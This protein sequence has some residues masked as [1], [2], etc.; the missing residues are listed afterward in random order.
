MVRMGPR[1]GPTMGPQLGPGG[2][3]AVSPPSG[4]GWTPSWQVLQL[5]AT[6]FTTNLVVSS[7]KVSTSATRYV[8]PSGNNAN[9]GTSWGAAHRSLWDALN[10][11]FTAGVAVTI[12]V[13]GSPDPLNPMM[14]EYDHAWRSALAV[15]AN[16]I[17]VSDEATLAPG[18]AISSTYMKPGGADLGTWALV[19]GGTPNVYSATLAAAPN[20]V[21]D[22][23]ILSSFGAGTRLTL[24]TSAADVEA[25]PGSYYFA[26][27][28][29][30]V[31]TADSRAPDANLRT[32]KAGVINGHINTA[33]VDCYIQGLTFE[34]GNARCLFIQAATTVTLVDCK[35]THGQAEGLSLTSTTAAGD[36]TLHL[37]R[38]K[39]LDC[40][41]DGLQY[42][43]SGAGAV[44][45]VLEWDCE[46][47]GNS[48]AGADQGSTAHFTAG[49]TSV[50][51][52][53]VNG[54]Y[55]HNKTQG[56]ADV[57]G[58][59]T[60]MLGCRF[61]GESTGAY[62][63]DAGT[64]WLHGCLMSGNTTDL[65]TDNASG[66]I[67]VAGTTYAT[68]SGPGTIATYTP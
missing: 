26:A 54:R 53:R 49:N 68:S 57:G 35:A 7:L 58:C 10:D 8:S 2:G 5:S 44:C 28:T 55:H 46:S 66:N 9:A 45:R 12:Y 1:M 43:T 14:Y 62:I 24:Q 37:I 6:Q 42:T 40:D 50:S 63:G 61:V 67:K 36:Y 16:V 34:G 29:L 22:A 41:A 3:H 56:V 27:G 23:S 4:F 39:A 20:A 31:R 13:K 18:Y 21:I 48:G 19:G 15:D 47:T 30:Y 64:G 52:I 38:C 11:A 60:W 25:N 65:V 32:L 33:S 59:T 51:V 17:V